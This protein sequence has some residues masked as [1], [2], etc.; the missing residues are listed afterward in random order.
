MTIKGMGLAFWKARS[1]TLPFFEPCPYNWEGKIFHCLWS[2]VI[3]FLFFKV[4]Y[5]TT[6]ISTI[7]IFVL[8]KSESTNNSSRIAYVMEICL[9]SFN[10]RCI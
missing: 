1:T 5:A 7:W 10:A 3:S 2:F 9:P 6:F 8:C 4:K